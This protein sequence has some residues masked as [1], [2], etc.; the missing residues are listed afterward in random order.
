MVGSSAN[1]LSDQQVSICVNISH[2]NSS[3]SLKKGITK[4]NEEILGN[5]FR[6]QFSLSPLKYL[7]HEQNLNLKHCK[8]LSGV[9]IKVLHGKLYFLCIDWKPEAKKLLMVSQWVTFNP[10]WCTSIYM[11]EIVASISIVVLGNGSR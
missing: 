5:N 9:S 2:P 10:S 8:D 6:K 7:V 1:K 4:K 11:K 3:D